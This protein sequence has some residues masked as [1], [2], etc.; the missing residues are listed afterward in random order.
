MHSYVSLLTVMGLEHL[1]L[2]FCNDCRM[3]AIFIY[4]TR[5]IFLLGFV[6]V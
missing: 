3:K 4:S 5:F 2:H 6:T 1:F